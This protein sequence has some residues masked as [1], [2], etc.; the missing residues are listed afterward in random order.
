[1]RRVEGSGAR[2]G[3]ELPDEAASEMIELSE[4]TSLVGVLNV[5]GDMLGPAIH[6]ST[7]EHVD[8]SGL[9]NVNHTKDPP[10]DAAIAVLERYIR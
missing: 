1:M 6:A 5:H 3:P 2:T 10:N 4:A 7:I 8:L 9:W